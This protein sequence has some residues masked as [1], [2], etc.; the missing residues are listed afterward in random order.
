LLNLC[1]RGGADR[2]SQQIVK[3]EF[4]KIVTVTYIMWEWGPGFVLIYNDFVYDMNAPD[5]IQDKT[6]NIPVIKI[7]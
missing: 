1:S 6:S 4:V 7:L 3:L 5:V 2:F